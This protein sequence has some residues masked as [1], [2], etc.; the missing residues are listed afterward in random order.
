MK[1]EIKNLA[2]EIK[3][4]I[5]DSKK[6]L[7]H[8]HPSPDEDSAG[9]VLAMAQ[10]LKSWGKDYTIISGDSHTPDF[11]QYL[12]GGEEIIDQKYLETDVSSYDLHLV[13][14]TGG[15]N[16]ITKRGAFTFPTGQKVV[17]ID[18][19]AT[20]NKFGTT[21]LVIEDYPATAQVLYELFQ[22]WGELITPEID[23]CLFAGIYGDII[24]DCDFTL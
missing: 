24:D 7:L 22:A 12:P 13:L 4:I 20:N 8:L 15:V 21:N 1:Q 18:H 16:Q 2:P 6:I 17:V 11:V 10:V 14:D 3:Q 23:I 19:H 9:S 5:L